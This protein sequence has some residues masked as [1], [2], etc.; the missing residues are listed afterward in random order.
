MVKIRSILLNSLINFINNLLRTPDLLLYN[1]ADDSFETTSTVNAVI[2]S[3]GSINYLPPGMFK[4]TCVIKVEDFPFDDQICELKFG[5]L[6][7]DNYI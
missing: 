2:E 7:I 3:T 4:S 6:L 1:S 5:R